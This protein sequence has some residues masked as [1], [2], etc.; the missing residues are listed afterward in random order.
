MILK[1]KITLELPQWTNKNKLFILQSTKT[2][3]SWSVRE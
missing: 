1:T 2:I 3:G